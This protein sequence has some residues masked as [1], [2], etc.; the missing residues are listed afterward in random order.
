MSNLIQ[1]FFY[2]LKKGCNLN[3]ILVC[4]F[5]L[6]PYKYELLFRRGLLRTFSI[7]LYLNYKL[8]ELLMSCTRGNFKPFYKVSNLDDNVI[9]LSI[10]ET[11][12]GCFYILKAL[13]AF[14]KMWHQRHLFINNFQ[15]LP[16][17]ACFNLQT[18]R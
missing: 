18:L 17:K 15:T 12:Q 3:F 9:I 11:M 5:S 10:T 6:N 13:K 14:F 1:F 2:T 16:A 7:F 8:T 4:F